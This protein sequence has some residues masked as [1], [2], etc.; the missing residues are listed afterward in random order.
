MGKEAELF[1]VMKKSRESG[2]DSLAWN[3]EDLVHL[4]SSQP[5]GFLGIVWPLNS[6]SDS[7]GICGMLGCSTSH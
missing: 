1:E 2:G 4:I 6:L 5:L 7:K 3:Q